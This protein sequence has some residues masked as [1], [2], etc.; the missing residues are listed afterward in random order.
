MRDDGKLQYLRDWASKLP[1][2]AVRIAG[3]MHCVSGI[4]TQNSIIEIS[5]VD[6]A[7]AL[8]ESLVSHALAVFDLMDRDQTTEDALR[9]QKWLVRR[10][11]TQ[12]SL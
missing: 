4:P 3:I 1:G 10:K 2:A 12:F 8:A 7:L 6:R 9:I 11:L 5:A